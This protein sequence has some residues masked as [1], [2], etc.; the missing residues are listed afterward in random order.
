VQ[1]AP[2]RLLLYYDIIILYGFCITLYFI[3]VFFER[4]CRRPF[5]KYGENIRDRTGPRNGKYQQ[6]LLGTCYT[7]L[8]FKS[9]SCR[10]MQS[11]PTRNISLQPCALKCQ[12]CNHLI[13]PCN[14]SQSIEQHDGWCTG[15]AQPEEELME[16]EDLKGAGG[17][18]RSARSDSSL[19]PLHSNIQAASG[20]PQGGHAL[21]RCC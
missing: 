21:C 13:S 8:E 20:L 11:P 2:I 15:P 14:S 18:P 16:E 12:S 9:Q 7:P 19:L 3:M 6:K 1:G 17:P 5:N 4:R 10:L